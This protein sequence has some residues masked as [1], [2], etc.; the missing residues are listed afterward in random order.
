[1]QNDATICVTQKFN[2]NVRQIGLGEDI[3]S[4]AENGR[5]TFANLKTVRKMT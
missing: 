2:V 5:W 3:R 4:T 1:M